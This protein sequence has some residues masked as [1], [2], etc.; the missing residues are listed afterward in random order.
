MNLLGC[1]V[2]FPASAT[3]PKLAARC[4]FW[5]VL[6]AAAHLFLGVRS[7]IVFGLSVAFLVS[8]FLRAGGLE[9]EKHGWRGLAVELIISMSIIA[10]LW[11][12]LTLSAQVFI[13]ISA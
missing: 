8:S 11:A 10:L 4:A 13:F 5:L 7:G 1:D 6:A 2:R 9:T 12:V 3:W